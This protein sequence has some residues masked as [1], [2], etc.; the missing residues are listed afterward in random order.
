[1]IFNS[2]LLLKGGQCLRRNGSSMEFNHFNESSIEFNVIRTQLAAPAIPCSLSLLLKGGEMPVA[3]WE[4]NHFNGSSIEF[5]VMRT[6]L[7]APAIH[8]GAMSF[9]RNLN[10]MPAAQWAIPCGAMSF[11]RN[12]SEIYSTNS[13]A[14]NC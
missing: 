4:F 11:G 7:A 2:S 12:G 3:Q 1:M 8:C 13:I 6:Q 9:G 5:N 10:S 14:E